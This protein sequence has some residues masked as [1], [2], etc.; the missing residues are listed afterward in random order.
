MAPDPAE[1]GAPLSAPGWRAA[2]VRTNLVAIVP[3]LLSLGLSLSTV[4]SQVFW[5]DSGFYLVAIHDMAVL[6]PHG[7]MLYLVLCK[8]WTLIF[9]FLDFTLAVHLFSSFCAAGA[10]ATLA[11]ASRNLLLLRDGPF[12]RLDEPRASLADWSGAAV[13]C[14]AASGF[15]FWSTAIYAKGYTLYYWILALLLCRILRASQ[16]GRPREFTRVAAL[17]GLSWAA[18]PSAALTGL[19][20]LLFAG[21]AL[22]RLGWKGL[23]WRAGL[24]AA[25]ALGPSLGVLALAARGLETSMD[26]PTTLG[27]FLRYLAGRRYTQLPGAFGWDWERASSFGQFLA[28]EVFVPGVVL[29]TA[30]LIV[31]VRARPWV[32]ASVLTWTVPFAFVTILFR[33]EGQHDCWFVAAWLPFY[34]IMAVGLEA[35]SRY[36]RRHA[37]TAIAA[38]TLLGVA[39]AAMENHPLLDQRRYDL[40]ETFGRIHLARLPSNAVLVLQGDDALATSRYLQRIRGERPDVLIVDGALLDTAPGQDGGWYDDLLL[41]RH[42]ELRPTL[43]TAWRRRLPKHAVHLYA[44]ASFLNSNAGGVRPLYTNAMIPGEMI[45]DSYSAVPAGPL[46]K[47]VPRSQEEIDLSDW[48][49]PVQPEQILPLLRRKRGIEVKGDA[50][51][52]LKVGMQ[53]YEARLI[54]LLLLAR[55]ALADWYRRKGDHAAA[56]N[57]W[58]SIRMVD[59]DVEENP[60]WLMSMGFAYAGLGEGARA[61]PLLERTVERGGAPWVRA[62][63]L[64]ALGRLA[65]DRGQSAEAAEYFRRAFDIHG[66]TMEQRL[67]I[68][69]Q[70]GTP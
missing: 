33:V 1:P 42:P 37:R 7:H 19:A 41:R 49:F 25:C 28:E 62:G 63:A 70:A 46:V 54:N 45:A 58:E 47:I 16:S 51:S 21:F 57:L 59:P 9:F 8:V 27:E 20:L 23:L 67:E 43:Y 39:W 5:Q 15:T 3:F 68:E 36:A 26:G 52:F 29:L 10:A 4:G 64:A 11:V 22:R 12:R 48:R 38:L 60:W 13:G 31:L 65:R 44:V 53:A 2:I 34:P 55:H 40:A 17:I 30:G 18:H 35:L 24:A 56:V 50:V 14:L 32:A 6:Y 69:R 61:R 66:L